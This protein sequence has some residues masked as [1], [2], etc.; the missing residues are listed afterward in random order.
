M[1]GIFLLNKSPEMTS[2]L[3]CNV[4]RKLLGVKKAGHAG[5]L[6]PMAVGVLPILCG[7]ATRALDLLP[8]HVPP[9]VVITPHAGELARLLTRIDAPTTRDEIM[10]ESLRQAQRACELTGATVVLKGAYT[11]IVGTDG[12]GG[13]RTLVCGRAPA[14]LATAGAGDVLAGIIGALLAQRAQE[15]IDDPTLVA[16]MAAGA[17]YTHGLAAAMAA[18][19][20]AGPAPATIT[21]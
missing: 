4:T 10:A 7:N 2:F 12:N 21:S 6:D 19:R 17:V 20:P 15:L 8:D 14:F 3:A 11:V 16:E 1:N 9:Q 5:T 13:M 18:Q